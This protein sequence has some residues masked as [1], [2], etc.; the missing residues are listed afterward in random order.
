[1]DLDRE[2]MYIR[3]HTSKV[4]DYWRVRIG[5]NDKEEAER[6]V[7]YASMTQEKEGTRTNRNRTPDGRERGHDASTDCVLGGGH[8]SDV[9]EGG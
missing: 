9:D 1:M 7:S 8:M 4:P 2:G 6:R 3:Y 5:N